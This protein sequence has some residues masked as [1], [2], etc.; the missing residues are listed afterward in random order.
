[1]TLLGHVHNGEI[2]LDQPMVLPEGA[3]V[4]VEVIAQQTTKLPVLSLLDRL[5]DIVGAVDDLPADGARNLDHYLY[6]TPKP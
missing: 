6:G 3:V 1:M 5:G 4:R 2:V